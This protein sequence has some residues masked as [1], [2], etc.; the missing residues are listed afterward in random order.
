MSDDR[1]C[2]GHRIG[3]RRVWLRAVVKERTRRC[4]SVNDRAGLRSV[5]NYAKNTVGRTRALNGL[6]PEW[7]A[8]NVEV[9]AVDLAHNQGNGWVIRRGRTVA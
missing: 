2:H 7:M 1:A 4:R 6:E 9:E 8:R 3:H 5:V